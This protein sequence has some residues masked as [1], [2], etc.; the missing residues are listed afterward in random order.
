MRNILNNLII[1]VSLMTFLACGQMTQVEKAPSISESIENELGFV[2]EHPS[3]FIPQ[4]LYCETPS[5]YI[6][7][8]LYCPGY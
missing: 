8:D 4:E 3:E 6:P 5:D 2:L 7:E 1:V